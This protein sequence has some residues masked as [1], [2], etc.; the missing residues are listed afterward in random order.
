M[1][2]KPGFLNPWSGNEV[3]LKS[4]HEQTEENYRDC[5]LFGLDLKLL[6]GDSLLEHKL[7]CFNML[8]HHS[9]SVMN[10]WSDDVECDLY[11]S[12]LKPH[13]NRSERTHHNHNRKVV[14]WK[15][16][17]VFIAPLQSIPQ[18][19]I[20]LKNVYIDLIYCILKSLKSNIVCA[21]SCQHILSWF[22][23]V[24]DVLFSCYEIAFVLKG[25]T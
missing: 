24:L 21:Q 1:T 22:L 23:K 20:N 12:Q 16:D 25:C 17:Y 3:L 14:L 2:L 13:W 7:L 19:L 4:L 18:A 11:E 15:D 5:F 8:L 10:F 9:L 6:F